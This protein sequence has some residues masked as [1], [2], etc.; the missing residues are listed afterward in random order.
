MRGL[1]PHSEGCAYNGRWQAKICNN[2]CAS[3]IWDGAERPDFAPRMA[4]RRAATGVAT[5]IPSAIAA[6]GA[7]AVPGGAGRLVERLCSKPLG[8]WARERPFAL[9]LRAT[10]ARARARFE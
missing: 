6:L 10:K 5:A 2:G 8:I 7:P 1:E 4:V 9:R 3:L